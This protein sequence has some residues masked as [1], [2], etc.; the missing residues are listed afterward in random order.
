MNELWI[1]QVLVRCGVH[2]IPQHLRRGTKN[3]H[4]ISWRWTDCRCGWWESGGNHLTVNSF[5]LW[6]LVSLWLLFV[7]VGELHVMMPFWEFPTMVRHIGWKTHILVLCSCMKIQLMGQLKFATLSVICKGF[8]IGLPLFW[9]SHKKASLS[10]ETIF[11]LIHFEASNCNIDNLSA[12]RAE[13]H[14]FMQ[15]S[16]FC[17]V[18]PFWL[19]QV[20]A[21]LKQIVSDNDCENED[22]SSHTGAMI[23]KCTNCL[24][25]KGVNVKRD[26]NFELKQKVNAFLVHCF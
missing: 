16:K 6:L 9:K 22:C 25:Q 26:A 1:T 24:W 17:K 13:V 19:V 21:Q 4:V 15:H 10:K 2:N 8:K 23:N 11:V 14:S 3:N 18:E 5:E 12:T 20:M 7:P